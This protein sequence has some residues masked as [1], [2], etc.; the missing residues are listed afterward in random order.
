MVSNDTSIVFSLTVIAC[1]ECRTSLG[2][3][4]VMFSVPIYGVLKSVIIPVTESVMDSGVDPFCGE[5]VNQSASEVTSQDRVSSLPIFNGV[6]CCSV[7]A[8]RAS[9][10]L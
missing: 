6:I 10:M 5:I 7:G 9:G 1:E 3:T 2:E 4:A 8:V